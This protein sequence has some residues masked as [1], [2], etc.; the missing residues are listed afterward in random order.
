M[1]MYMH[2]DESTKTQEVQTDKEI[3][4]RKVNIRLVMDTL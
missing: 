2:K 4:K 3:H 1:Y